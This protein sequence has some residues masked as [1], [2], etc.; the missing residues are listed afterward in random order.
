MCTSIIFEPFF[1]ES[2]FARRRR[3][4]TET[5]I[6]TH[7]TAVEWADMAICLPSACRNGGQ[8]RQ[9]AQVAKGPCAARGAQ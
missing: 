2:Q 4:E 5:K 9:D 1:G 7:C 8:V 6:W 3:P